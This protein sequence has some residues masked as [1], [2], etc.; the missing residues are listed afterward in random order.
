[1]TTVELTAPHTVATPCGCGGACGCSDPIGL[2]RTRFFPRM[3]VG[4]DELTQDQRWVKD[5]L[6]RHNRLLH[7]WGVVCGCN[8]TQATDARGRPVPW[9]VCVEEGY[10]LGPYGDE[11]VVDC[12]V[13][14]DVRTASSEPGPC[15][16]PAD[17]W[18]AEVH[19]ERRPDEVFYVSVRYDEHL[20][21][22]VRTLAGC[23]C[24]CDD[25]ECEYSRTRE[26]FALTALGALP[27]SYR[28]VNG[29]GG[30]AEGGFGSALQGALTCSQSMAEQV[31]PC[32]PCPADPWVVLADV[33]A[34][35]DGILQVDPITHR[36]Y[37]VSFGAYG[38]SCGPDESFQKVSAGLRK[39]VM[40][41]LS[42]KG[43]TELEERGGEISF[44]E[45]MNATALKG[46]NPRTALGRFV[47]D[48]SIGQVADTSRDSFVE[49][50]KTAGVDTTRA[51]ELWDAARNVTTLV[52][53][54][55]P[56]S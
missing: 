53:G 52:R 18:C 14:F 13:T 20:T 15:T 2:E 16:P 33:V 50:A 26:S 35:A 28:V 27:E 5:K 38:F 22:P 34:N 42:A 56:D 9:V 51:R 25:A 30:K 48:R 45:A 21:R 37:V 41:S 4:P 43:A 24:G 46:V 17:P 54:D 12:P 31:R 39:K 10:V 55:G 6:R 8:V 3:L 49:E 29:Q 19:V 40:F 23:G 11:I 1:M 36:R 32:P 44:A 47:A 7:G